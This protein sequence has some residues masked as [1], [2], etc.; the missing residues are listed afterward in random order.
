MAKAKLKSKSKDK[1]RANKPDREPLRRLVERARAL[2]PGA[3]YCQVYGWDD[4]GAIP[5]RL[6]LPDE[7]RGALR[8]S[9]LPSRAGNA[10]AIYFD[11]G[12]FPS[13]SVGACL[14]RARP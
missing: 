7:A 12:L 8:F 10:A 14:P 2:C 9:F 4:A 3:S 13:P 5:D 11:C 1:S 6:P